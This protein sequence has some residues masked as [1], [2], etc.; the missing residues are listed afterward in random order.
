VCVADAQTGVTPPQSASDRQP[1]Q[2]PPPDEVLQRGAVGAQCVVLAGEQAAQ[3]PVGRQ[4]G[5]ATPHSPSAAQGR[6]APP[7]AQTGEV[8][9]QST[10]PAQPRQ[11]WVAPSQMGAEPLQSAAA[12]QPTHRPAATSQNGVPPAQSTLPAQA[13]QLCVPESQVGVAPPHV[14]LVAQ[15]TQVPD[16]TLQTGVTPPQRLALVAE[17]APQAPLG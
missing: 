7:E 17:Q 14:A 13:R 8:P 15:P 9:R 5:A 16:G 2:A 3:A 12:R 10:L 6:Q 11:A 1:T 4:T